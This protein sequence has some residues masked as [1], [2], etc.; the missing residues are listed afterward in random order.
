MI[1]S[2]TAD[3][4]HNVLLR[5]DAIK[6][7]GVAKGPAPKP[8]SSQHNIAGRQWAVRLVFAN[9]RW[10]EYPSS[11]KQLHSR[12]S[13]TKTT[14]RTDRLHVLE[15]ARLMASYVSCR[16]S[17]APCFLCD[18]SRVNLELLLLATAAGMPLSARRARHILKEFAHACPARSILLDPAHKHRRQPAC[19]SM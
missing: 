3:S 14:K 17:A 15:E 6:T 11:D 5:G 1:S 10:L 12:F 2:L 16:H 7:K 9:I 19:A 18:S 13:T 4:R 8:N